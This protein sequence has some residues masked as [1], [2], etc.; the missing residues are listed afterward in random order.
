[1][2]FM[3]WMV[4]L[5]TLLMWSGNWIVARGARDD[6]APGLATGARLVLVL[7]ILLPLTWRGLL[8]KL[9]ALS[10]VDWWLL[11]A[12]GL[13]GG[14]VPMA[15]Q[16]L[17]LHYTTATS[18]ILYL[19]ASPVFILLFALPLGE[20]IRAPQIAGVAV[21]LAG[22]AVIAAQGSPDRLAALS[23]NTGDLLVLGSTIMFAAY[24]V[25]LRVRRLALDVAEL[26]SLVCACGLLF[27]LPWIAWDLAAGQRTQI[28]AAAAL[29]VLYS[30]VCSQLLA[31]LGWSHVVTRLGAGL[32]GATLH[33]MPAMG[34]GLAA[35]FLGEYPEGFH[36]AGIA[37]ILAGVALS[38]RRVKMRGSSIEERVQ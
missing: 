32:S 37:L 7:A 15:L 28:N 23:F 4:L 21:S 31:Y 19:S 11:V 34:V 2:R 13:T 30:A 8:A 36:F 1:M 20:R 9:P 14:G 16:W 3:S 17:G 10:R 26:L 33:L 25:L 35:V 29:A 38:S 27:M 5:A 6:I 18:G 22:V 12:L 24:T